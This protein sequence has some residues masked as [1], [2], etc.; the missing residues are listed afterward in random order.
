MNITPIP[1][2]RVSSLE[3]ATQSSASIAGIESQV[4]TLGQELSSGIAV[5][6]PSDDPSAAVVIQTLKT[7]LSDSSQYSTNVKAATDQLDNVDSTLSN[8]G[9]LLTQA[10]ST[11][12]TNDNTT[13][14][15][16]QRES[17]AE[18]IDSIYN[19]VVATANTTYGGRY[20]FGTD[21]AARRPRTRS[22]GRGYC[23]T[24]G[25]TGTLSGQTD[26]AEQLSYQVAGGRRSSAAC[27]ASVSAG[28]D[29]SPKVLG[30]TADL[31]V[32]LAGARN[33]TGVTLGT[34][35][36]VGNG[37]V[38]TT[39]VDLTAGR[40]PCR[41]WSTPS[42]AAGV[43]GRDG[44][45]RREPAFDL[46]GD[47]RGERDRRRRGPAARRPP[48]WGSSTAHRRRGRRG[49]DRGRPGQRRT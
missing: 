16:A 1:S 46:A 41:T 25:R 40:A 5:P 21:D 39:A 37:T 24:T 36:V 33:A 9:T 48:T 4:S 6:Q 30:T 31:I 3:R 11:A 18:Q 10:V 22:T 7:Q 43:A 20:V 19:Q 14:T 27:S 8:L 26:A 29:L 23:S 13:T 35:I 49:R 34:V 28:T 2:V 15:A 45:G 47:R 44:V 42:N 38:T 32:D 17:A 12:G